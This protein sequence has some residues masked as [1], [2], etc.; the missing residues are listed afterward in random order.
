MPF[1]LYGNRLLVL[2][3]CAVHSVTEQTS[4]KKE[5]YHTESWRN[6]VWM[7]EE[8][9]VL[10]QCLLNQLATKRGKYKYKLD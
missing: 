9:S 3:Q 2:T 7:S 5:I 10:A 1:G 8:T 4:L 6:A